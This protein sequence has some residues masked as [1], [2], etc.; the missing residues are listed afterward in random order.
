MN[1]TARRIVNVLT[2]IAIA[3]M[4]VVALLVLVPAALGLE[5]YVITSGSMSGSIDRGSLIFDQT[6][7]VADLQKGD[8]I[9]YVPP[10]PQAAAGPVTHRIVWA[11]K[12]RFGKPAFRTKGDANPT[13]DP[14]LFVLKQPT[15]A[16]VKFDVPYA[17]Y[18][19][20]A[21]NVR[22]LRMLLIGLPA[23]LIAFSVM[24]S[25]V[26]DAR[27]EQERLAAAEVVAS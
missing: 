20:A 25:L 11:G 3:G 19:L 17:G 8:V 18:V 2:A 22:T 9:T 4:L 21:L 1:H 6:V 14:W 12:D 15:Q 16:R 27:A 13:V 26:R 23:L 7:P 5:R 24:R 10:G